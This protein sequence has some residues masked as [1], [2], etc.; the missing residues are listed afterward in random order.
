M[1]LGGVSN[2][3][4]DH[5]SGIISALLTGPFPNTLC[6][7]LPGV[8]STEETTIP[9]L[10]IDTAGC[11]LFELEVE[12]EQSK[13][14]PGTIVRKILLVR[15]DCLRSS[16]SRG[17]GHCTSWATSQRCPP[18]EQVAG[19]RWGPQGALLIWE[20][21]SSVNPQAQGLWARTEWPQGHDDS[22]WFVGGHAG[23]LFPLQRPCCGLGQGGG[24]LRQMLYTSWQ[25]K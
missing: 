16:A 5:P 18:P 12:D 22:V 20:I 19:G 13:G 4:T 1:L 8:T 2:N 21:I 14:N 23:Y 3:I 15:I 25:G 6:R 11:G 17:L 24:S 9:L 7:D 10:L